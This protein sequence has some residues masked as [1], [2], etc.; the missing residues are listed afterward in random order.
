MK[1]WFVIKHDEAEKWTASYRGRIV[2]TVSAAALREKLFGMAGLTSGAY[3]YIILQYQIWKQL[4]EG[5]DWNTDL[6]RKGKGETR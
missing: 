5:F 2:E 4:Q 6:A 3:M 1:D